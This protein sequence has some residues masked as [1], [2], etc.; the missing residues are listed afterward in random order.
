MAKWVTILQIKN[1]PVQIQVPGKSVA[2][3]SSEL[4]LC[5]AKGKGYQ[6]YHVSEDVKGTYIYLPSWQVEEV[7]LITMVD[8]DELQ[9]QRASMEAQ[10][11]IRGI[12]N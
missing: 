9:R 6:I 7:Q 8:L 12:Q 1:L 3:V 5:V 11:K 2:E 10:Q 4:E